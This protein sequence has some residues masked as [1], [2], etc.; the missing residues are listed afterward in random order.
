M[1]RLI[2]LLIKLNPGKYSLSRFKE[3]IYK[4][5]TL[6]NHRVL[7][8]IEKESLVLHS[9]K[10]LSRVSMVTNYGCYR[11]RQLMLKN[12]LPEPMFNYIISVIFE[13]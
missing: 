7:N 5:R 12:K 8:R 2:F 10:H 6:I 1:W 3:M 13:E 4:T 11:L 9:L